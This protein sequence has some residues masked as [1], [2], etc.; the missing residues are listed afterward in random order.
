VPYSLVNAPA[1]GYDL[2]RLPHGEQ[3]ADVLRTALGCSPD[4]LGALAARHPGPARVERW[5]TVLERGA[6][7]GVRDTLVL[8]DRALELAL[9]GDG[10][11]SAVLLRRLERAALGDVAG[12]DRLIRHDVLD[13]TWLRS[14]ELAVQDPGAAEACD[15]LADAAASAYCSERLD[16]TLRRSM[17]APYLG[18]GLDLAGGPSPHPGVR[19][20]LDMLV[21]TDG[22]TRRAWRKAVDEVRPGTRGWAPAMHQAGWAVMLADRLRTAADAQMQAVQAFRAAGFDARD[23]SYGVWNAVSGVVQATVAADLL[24]ERDR[25][26]LVAVWTRVQGEEPPTG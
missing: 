20:V 25:Q 21:G 12:L 7:E 26:R 15:V 10:T 22:S 2:V 14:G 19:T 6:R 9:T 23:A 3:V 5:S 8:A 18:A 17:A 4:H 13:W 16:D 11:S 1:L 24:P